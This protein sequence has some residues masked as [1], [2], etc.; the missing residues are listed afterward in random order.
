VLDAR[1][2]RNE[3]ASSLSHAP[4]RSSGSRSQQAIPHWAP[5]HHCGGQKSQKGEPARDLRD[6]REH[7]RRCRGE[8]DEFDR[9]ATGVGGWRETSRSIWER[10]RVRRRLKGTEVRAGPA[11]PAAS[12]AVKE[13]DESSVPSPAKADKGGEHVAG[14]QGTPKHISAR[15]TDGRSIAKRNDVKEA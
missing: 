10:C 15:A 1:T 4:A 7:D 2:A 9:L 13:A 12:T 14:K 8:Q 5:P 11:S 6:Q 3:T